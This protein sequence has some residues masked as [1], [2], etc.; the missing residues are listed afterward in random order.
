MASSIDLPHWPTG[1]VAFLVTAGPRPHAI[2]V[3]AVV[4]AA[5]DRMLLGLARRRRSLKRLR[6]DPEVTVALCARDVAVSIDGTATVVDEHLTDAVVAVSVQVTELHDHDR[7][8]FVLR[9]GVD[10][11]WTDEPARGADAEV[12]AALTRLAGG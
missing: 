10:W 6:A 1:T 8:T 9:G 12:R 4:R 7:P 11:A 3:S 2:P 5:D